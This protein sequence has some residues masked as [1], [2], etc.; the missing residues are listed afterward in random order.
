MKQCSAQHKREILSRMAA[1]PYCGFSTRVTGNV[2]YYYKSFVGRDFKAWIQMAIFIISPYLSSESR[3]CWLLL[4]QVLQF[5]MVLLSRAL[6]MSLLLGLSGS[7]LPS[8]VAWESS[9]LSAHLPAVCWLCHA[10]YARVLQA[11]EN[12]YPPSSSWW[13]ARLWSNSVL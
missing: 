6:A 10:A 8:C 7:L 13:H 1:F 12:P 2:C 3:K 4:S 9:R 5:T 11:T